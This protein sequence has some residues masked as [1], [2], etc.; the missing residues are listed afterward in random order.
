[1]EIHNYSRETQYRYRYIVTANIWG[2]MLRYFALMSTIAVLVGCMPTHVVLKNDPTFL[3]YT[4]DDSVITY[5]IL[6]DYDEY[7]QETIILHRPFEEVIYE[8]YE[9]TLFDRL[10]NAL[11]A[12][13][14]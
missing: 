3:E 10:A 11:D 5:E 2:I 1:M 13:I 14:S 4:Y 9:P 8:D 7:T 6:P 12:L